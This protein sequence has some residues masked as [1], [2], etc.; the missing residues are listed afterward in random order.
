MHS[1][2]S[3]R[4]LKIVV[5]VVLAAGIGLTFIS[6]AGL[7]QSPPAA[8]PAAATYKPTELQALKLQVLQKDA[9]LAQI[10]LQ[11]AQQAFQGALAALDAEAGAVK[12]ANNWPADVQFSP[13]T[14]TFEVPK[15]P[16]G[17][18]EATPAPAP[19]APAPAEKKPPQ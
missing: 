8:P 19:A 17:Q 2:H 16:A 15:L 9:Q 5:G 12:K 11:R 1:S 4:T 10:Q 3:F 18:P 6:V 13:D 7:A 14:L